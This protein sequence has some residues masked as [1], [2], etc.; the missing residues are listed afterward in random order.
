[1]S[2]SEEYINNRLGRKQGDKPGSGPGGVCIC[3]KCDYEVEHKIGQPCNEII[4]PKCR[5]PMTKK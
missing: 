5:I 2:I 3:K 4:C 1:M